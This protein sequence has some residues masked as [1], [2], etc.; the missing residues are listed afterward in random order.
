MPLGGVFFE[1]ADDGR[2]V[3]TSVRFS[4]SFRAGRL[5]ARSSDAGLRLVQAGLDACPVGIGMVA[6]CAGLDAG[7]LV[8][9]GRDELADETTLRP[10]LSARVGAQLHKTFALGWRVEIEGGT[11][12]PCLQDRYV[13]ERSDGSDRSLHDV[14]AGGYARLAI[15]C[16]L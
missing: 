10:S 7:G 5:G 12:L 6:L 8:V 3:W 4:L 11:V 14:T 15:G 1:L 16:R 2:N 9:T 13:V